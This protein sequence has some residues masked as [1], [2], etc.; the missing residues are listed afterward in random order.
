MRVCHAAGPNLIPGRD[1]LPGRGFSGFFLTFK[2]IQEA[3][4]P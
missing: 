1:K 4:D 2:T 3:L